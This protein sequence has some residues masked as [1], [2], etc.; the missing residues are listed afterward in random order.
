MPFARSTWPL[1]R[2]WAT[3]RV[4]DVDETILAEV[5]EHYVKTLEHYVKTSNR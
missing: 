1:H 2:G 3:E 4:V 5:L